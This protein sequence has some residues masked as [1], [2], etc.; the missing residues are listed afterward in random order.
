MKINESNRAFLNLLE[1]PKIKCF[2]E[3]DKCMALM[4]K[5]ILAA[6]LLFFRRAKFNKY[7]YNCKNFYVTLYLIHELYEEIVELKDIIIKTYLGV[8]SEK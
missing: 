4:D 1:H 2:L 6:I 5:Y 8:K 3:N 7:D